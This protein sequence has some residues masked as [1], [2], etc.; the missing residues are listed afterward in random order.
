VDTWKCAELPAE[1]A[2]LRDWATRAGACVVQ[3]DSEFNRL[4]DLP[5]TLGPRVTD[6][7][8]K[9][10][11]L[12]VEVCARANPQRSYVEYLQLSAEFEKLDQ[13]WIDPIVYMCAL[14][15]QFVRLVK[16]HTISICLQVAVHRWD[17]RKELEEA[18]K[19]AKAKNLVDLVL[20]CS[21]QSTESQNGTST[22]SSR[23]RATTGGQWVETVG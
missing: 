9:A 3:A 15:A 16:R 6:L 7:G 23:G 21:R 17:K 12:E 18:A 1:I 8:G 11:K 13:D 4:A 2:T 22:A 5:K 14:R 20:E 10:K 19:G